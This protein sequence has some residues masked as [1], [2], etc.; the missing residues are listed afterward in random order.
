VREEG[1]GGGGEVGWEGGD[2]AGRVVSGRV[3]EERGMGCMAVWG[4]CV[5]RETEEWTD[6]LF[7]HIF[8]R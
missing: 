3:G 1:E 5:G 7:G 4:E 8:L 6:F 2:P